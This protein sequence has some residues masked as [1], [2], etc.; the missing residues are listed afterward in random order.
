VVHIQ[1]R[2]TGRWVARYVDPEGRERARTFSK[3]SDAERFLAATEYSVNTGGYIDPTLG[4][5][6]VGKWYETWVASQGH[7]KASSFARYK[8][9]YVTHIAKRW[10]DVPVASI[11]TSAVQS[12]CTSVAASSSPSAAIK[13]HRVLSLM[14]TLAVQDGRIVRNPAEA[15]RLPR[16]IQVERRYLTH[17]QV[18]DLADAANRDR[19]LVL[20]LAYSGCRFGEMAALR[21]RR[22]DVVRRRVEI[23]ES[24]TA[25]DGTLVW[26][27]PK[28]HSHRWVSVPRFI[29]D[30]MVQHVEGKAGDAL[31]FESRQGHPLRSTNFRRDV[32]APAC[33]ATGL[34]TLHPHELR[35]T[36]ASLAIASGANVKV[37]QSMLGHKSA[38][39]TLDLYGHLF[40]DQLDVVADALDAAARA[41][42]TGRIPDSA[43]DPGDAPQP[44]R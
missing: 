31:I 30:E 1:K 17:Q 19:L 37:V 16:E 3:K 26:G 24:V 14:L 4:K 11:T 44:D 2:G 20:F 36:A 21:V 39:L 27:T 41:A 42:T 29:A 32:F 6:T 38:T 10:G 8:S 40:A 5:I 43:T 34:G 9:S 33:E 23:A 28:G 12:W 7:L 15:V 13:A 35:H 22:F 18:F 25:V